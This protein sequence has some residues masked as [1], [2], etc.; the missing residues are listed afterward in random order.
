MAR[1]LVGISEMFPYM[2]WARITHLCV[3]PVIYNIIVRSHKGAEG[4][5]IKLL[6][7]IKH[8]REDYFVNQSTF[9]SCGGIYFAVFIRALMNPG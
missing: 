1:Q 7:S 2:F 4:F 6:L 5:L 3:N 8:T 9:I